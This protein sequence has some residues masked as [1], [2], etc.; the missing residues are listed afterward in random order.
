[1][2]KIF[3]QAPLKLPVSGLVI[4]KITICRR[5]LVEKNGINKLLYTV[6]TNELSAEHTRS[7]GWK[8]TTR[9][10]REQEANNESCASSVFF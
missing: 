3:I 9:A 8:L 6:S 1:M 2:H 10:E 7:K 5:G 4:Y